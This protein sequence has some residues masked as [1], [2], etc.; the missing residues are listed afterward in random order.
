MTPVGHC[1]AGATLGLLAAPREA[2]RLR[3]TLTVAGCA[4]IAD[5]PDIEIPLWGH[6]KYYFS[7]SLFS[8]LMMICVVA[9][10]LVLSKRLREWVGSHTVVLGGLAAWL[11]HFVLD[12]FYNTGYGVAIYWP[13]NSAKLALPLPWFSTLGTP[14]PNLS[15]HNLKVMGIEFLFYGTLFAGAALLRIVRSGSKSDTRS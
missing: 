11:S 8:N 7:H 15:W 9:L 10:M 3:V 5:I 14:F 12:S 2:S 4:L 1:I 13:F 6:S